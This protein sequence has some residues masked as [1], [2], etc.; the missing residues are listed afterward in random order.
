MTDGMR[1][2]GR[3]YWIRRKTPLSQLGIVGRREI[4]VSLR[5]TCPREACRRARHVH[6]AV[7]RIFALAA[8]GTKVVSLR[9]RRVQEAIRALAQEPV[10]DG[11]QYALLA[12]DIQ[13]GN[14]SE[15]DAIMSM[16]GSEKE[17]ALTPLEYRRLKHQLERLLLHMCVRKTQNSLDQAVSLA[18]A[19]SSAHKR[20]ISAQKAEDSPLFSTHFERF[21]AYKKGESSDADGY[22]AQTESQT[23]V[24]G[25][26]FRELMGDLHVGSIS[27]R[28]ASEFRQLLLRVPSNL[29][30]SPKDPPA[31]T[32]I[33][34]ADKEEASGQPAVK[35]LSMTTVKRHFSSMQQYWKW[36]LTHDYV[37][38]NPFERWE[39]PRKSAARR[40]RADWPDDDLVRLFRSP[41]F[42]VKP[43]D[44]TFRWVPAIALLSGMRV[45]EIC[46]LRPQDVSFMDMAFNIREHEDGWSPKTEA[47]SRLVPIH[48]ALIELG[49]ANLVARRISESA[50]R[51]FPGLKSGGPDGKL[52][53]DPSRQ[54]S[55]LKIGMGFPKN[56]VFHSFRAT[57]RTKVRNATPPLPAEFI[58]ATI[59]HEPGA[60]ASTGERVYQKRYDLRNLRM[61]IDA[62]EYPPAVMA[63][64]RLAVTGT[65]VT[66][67]E[68]TSIKEGALATVDESAIEE[69][70][71]LDEVGVTEFEPGG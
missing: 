59:G 1:L 48:K 7:D 53:Y 67:G 44:S 39:F 47:G 51:L 33:E 45:E 65:E 36:L 55:R 63:T 26:L 41:L 32:A 2:R 30:K 18:E 14:D 43:L 12:E 29:G 40:A 58:D 31:P 24:T 62:L 38:A 5:T 4:N 15:F 9:E 61:V 27:R 34:R 50:D 69:E 13:A 60:D 25:R 16:L 17:P 54:F 11:E 6:I 68:I 20:V 49:F 46:R 8:D 37:A 71:D 19:F 23:R 66:S 22:T 56:Q 70:V 10:W 42:R 28:T 64:L 57:V 52:G 35:R 3:I 21:L